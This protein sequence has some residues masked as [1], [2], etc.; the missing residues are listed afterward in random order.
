MKKFYHLLTLLMLISMAN[1]FAQTGVLNP[2]DPIVKYNAASPPAAPNFNQLTKWVKTDRVGFNTDDYKCYIYKGVQF[3]LKFPKSYQHGVNDG[4]TYPLIIFFHGV[5]EA[6]T[7][8]DNEYSLYHGGQLH[9]QK[10]NDGSFDGFLFYPQNDNGFYGAGDYSTIAEL[11]NNYF[12]PEVK[13]DPNRIIVEGLSGGGSATWEFMIAYPKLVAAA[14]PISAASLSFGNSANS[15][16]YTSVWNFQG[17]DDTN[18]DPGTSQALQN[19]I[20]GVGGNIKRTVYPGVGHGC[21]YNAW[22][23]SDF[24]PWANRANKTNPWPLY[25]KTIFCPNETINVTLGVT[26]GFDGYEWMKN[27]T[28]IAGATG[29]TIVATTPGVYKARL[30]RG[31]DWSYWSP[32]PVTI[33]V[34]TGTPPPAI[35]VVPTLS[36]NVIPTPAGVNSVQ[37]RV[38]TDYLGFKWKKTSD[39]ATT[40]GTS[41]VYNAT[42]AGNYI[43]QVTD[44]Q[45]CNSAQ[46][47]PYLVV[48]AAG[49]NAPPAATGLTAVAVNESSIRLYWNEN[50]APQYDETGFEVY[51]TSTPG[52]NYQLVG[53]VGQGVLTFTDI[54]LSPNTQYYY[55]VRAVNGNGAA[56]VTPEATTTTENGSVKPPSAPGNLTASNITPTSMQL[57]WTAS[58]GEVAI[59]KYDIYIN[60]VKTYTIDAPA[61]TYGLYGLTNRTVYNITIK[62]RDVRGNTSASSNQ[63]TVAA[64]LNGLNYK[65][66]TTPT[67]WSQL[68]NFNTLTPVKEGVVNNV[69]DLSPATQGD[70]FGF[71]WT[72]YMNIPATGNYTFELKSDDGSAF[73]L[74][75]YNPTGTPTINHDGLHGSTYSSPVTLYLTKGLQKVAFAFFEAGGGQDMAIWWSNTPTGITTRQLVPNSVFNDTLTMPTGKPANPT[76]LVATSPA[77]N[78]V[79]LSWNDNSNNESGFEIYRAT[80][81]AGPF[82]VIATNNA[83]VKTYVDS[84]VNASTQYFYRVQAINSSG[85]S[86]F[87]SANT[88]TQALPAVPAAATNLLATAASTTSVNVTWND[89]ATN[90]LAYEVYRSQPNNSNYMLLKVLPANTT[91]YVDEDLFSNSTYYYKVRA[92]NAGGNGNYSN[93][94]SATTK[95]NIPVIN[96]NIG[97]RT[98]RYGTQMVIEI[99]TSDADGEQ[100]TYYGSNIPSFGFLNDNGNGTATLAFNPTSTDQNTY[101]NIAV[102]VYDQHGGA[103][104]IT[105]NLVVNDNFVPALTAISNVT[106]NEA[107]TS[108][109]NL[110]ASDDN[111][112][113]VLTWTATGLPSFATLTT[114]NRTASIALAPGYSDNGTYPITITVNDGNGGVDTKSFTIT[115]NDVNPNQKIYVSFGGSGNTAAAPWNRTAKAPA[116]N[117]HFQNLKD[118]NNVTTTLGIKVVTNWQNIGGG[119]AT[120]LLGVNTGN[121][122]GIYPDAV[123]RSAYWTQNAKQTIKLT[124]CQ[125][126]FK[127]TFTFFGSR[128]NPGGAGPR[129]TRY[130]INGTAVTLDAIGNS[131]NTVA[132]NNVLPTAGEITIDIENTNNEYGYLNAL[133]I[134]ALYDDGNPPAKPRNVSAET[135]ANGVKVNW[136]DAAFNES[137]YYVYRSTSKAGTYTLLNSGATNANAVTYTDAT[138]VAN[139]TYFYY[140]QAINSY[141]ASASS[142][143]V[144]IKAANKNPIIA[145]IPAVLAKTDT[146]IYVPISVSDDPGEAIT[147]SSSTLPVFATLV[148][149]GNGSGNLILAPNS[150]HIGKYTI[151][152]TATDVNGGSDTK[153]VSVTVKDKNLTSYYINF[154]NSD[155]A[156]APWNNFNKLPTAGA[157]IANVTDETGAATSIGVTVVNA[158][159]GANDLGAVTGN[160]SGVYP[161]AVMKT[162]YYEETTTAKSVKFTGLD[163]NKKYNLVFFGSRGA[164]TDNRSTN[165]TVGST[166]VTLNAA[167]NTTNTVQINGVSPTNG[168]I[169]FSVQRGTGSSYGYLGAVV[170]QGYVDN[171][172]PPAPTALQALSPNRTSVTLKWQDKTSDEI[173]FEIYRS[174]TLL[175]TYTL[176]TT[177]AANVT[178]YTNTGLTANTKYYYKVR[179]K[180]STTSFSD[181][182]NVAVITTLKYGVYVNFSVDYGAAAPWNN[183]NILPYLGQQI[184]NP[185]DDDGNGT[186]MLITTIRNFTGTNNV[187]MNTGN[188]SGVVPDNVMRES[189]YLDRGDTA[190]LRVS[191]LNQSLVYSFTFFGSRNGAGDRTTVYQIGTTTVNLNAA[192]NTAN[193]VTIHKVVPNSDGE[194]FIRVYGSAASQYGYLNGLI[195]QASNND[196]TGA[197]NGMT[198]YAK[199]N[200]LRDM[201]MAA[202]NS[203]ESAVKGHSFELLN[204]FPN[205]FQQDLY[206][207]MSKDGNPSRIAGL[208]YDMTGRLVHAE[209]FGSFS[210]TNQSK[211]N[212]PANLPPGMYLLQILVDGKAEKTVKLI[213]R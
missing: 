42:S 81:S 102:S 204:A 47:N 207:T 29:N 67:A 199:K 61:T 173:G 58:V 41:N 213:K 200:V 205:P 69:S 116:I 68:P 27:D 70:N 195:V 118:A 159:T 53:I 164:V 50:P 189:Y 51:R 185:T 26:A 1:A 114:S 198:V 124:G 87:I 194:I 115:V 25:G 75:D 63:L 37:M 44:L 64:K 167:S 134:D 139:T 183:T 85:S 203:K 196:G 7:N 72:G 5:G 161:D 76:S 49:N 145:N 13:V 166:T 162:A 60:G 120:N 168:E 181:Y 210:G 11:I 177:T 45:G 9:A 19:T 3:R 34:R 155:P 74:G 192:L 147:L 33:S 209:V 96:T 84:L 79:N 106:L 169:T 111:A 4:K 6:G 117:D 92:R 22:G 31:S 153:T 21:W 171:G 80:A 157:A 193:T 17:G 18:P 39:T 165:Y 163:A 121:N 82:V 135:V 16:K 108:T 109:V 154:N 178:T 132:I 137:A 136:V 46:S 28:L 91:S 152:I 62:A 142:D 8:Y 112:A 113:D 144:S 122:S 176:V 211:V 208:L 77:Y 103:D 78:K 158:F 20:L 55:I 98:M 191:G 151:N 32:I 140:L 149:N 197:E 48:N 182:S 30:K 156:A 15:F 105:F 170:L 43:V 187:G 123:I 110:T 89:V 95:N 104:T 14:G 172:I 86:N 186:G 202:K 141:G 179:A 130:T 107:A 126:N 88:T 52:A 138:A 125:P 129:L 160:N 24:F 36:S 101:N 175:G 119:D 148:D 146:T 188:N 90:E 201:E 143:T 83:N 40:L 38:P 174:T 127:Y 66:Y 128:T 59:S 94:S 73:Y 65:F 184:V 190:I 93:E 100:L 71:L 99:T 206:L 12:V 35:S 97:N 54:N 133:V 131:T 10:V 2:A 150:L 57:N 56:A 23:E 180:I 212:V